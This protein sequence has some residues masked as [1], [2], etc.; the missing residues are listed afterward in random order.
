MEVV[1]IY[2]AVKRLAE[3]LGIDFSW[4]STNK[5]VKSLSAYPEIQMISLIVIATKV[6]HP[7]DDI[8]RVPENDAEP[9]TVRM[10]WPEW[11]RKMAEPPSRGLKRGEE[12]KITDA[13][14]PNMNAKKIDDY[15]DWYQRTW[16]DD[17]DPKS[18][19]QPFP[20]SS[21]SQLCLNVPANFP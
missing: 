1:E 14:I 9:T 15:L 6:T 11:A 4:P 16:V 20:E 17:S 10:D 12:V 3:L 19:F 21:I 5:R 8:P 18:T 7:F 2:P 13:D